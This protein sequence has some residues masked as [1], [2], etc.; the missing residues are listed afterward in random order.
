MSRWPG[1]IDAPGR[2][3]GRCAGNTSPTRPY[4]STTSIGSVI[5]Q[6]SART[7]ARHVG[8]GAA[9]VGVVA[10]GKP[11]DEAGGGDAPRDGA[12]ETNGRCPM[13]SRALLVKAKQFE[14]QDGNTMCSDSAPTCL[15]CIARCPP[16]G[17]DRSCR[18]SAKELALRGPPSVCTHRSLPTTTH[19]GNKP[20]QI[21]DTTVF[22]TTLQRCF[23]HKARC[24]FFSVIAQ[25]NKKMTPPAWPGSA[26]LRGSL[27][28]LRSPNRAGKRLHRQ[29]QATPCGRRA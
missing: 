27:H 18:I 20:S 28:R 1:A 16:S 6:R 24:G 13:T 23:F 12:N 29:A 5:K 9:S 11:G 25:S 7:A 10:R 8:V 21:R 15:A 22:S 2:R 4:R 3:A 26:R 14:R 19:I 17:P